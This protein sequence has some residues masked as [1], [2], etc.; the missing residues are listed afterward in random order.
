MSLKVKQIAQSHTIRKVAEP[1]IYP[2]M[3]HY[4]A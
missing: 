1:S 2:R 4:K 3:L